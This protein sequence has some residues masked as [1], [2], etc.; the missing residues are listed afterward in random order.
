MG[1]WKMRDAATTFF[2]AAVACALGG[3]IW[4]IQM[5]MSEN[6]LLA[7]AHAHLALVG[8]VTLALFGIYYRLTPLANGTALS[9]IHALTAIPGVAVMVPGIAI[10]VQGGTSALAAAGAI[11]SL[12]SMVIFFVTVLRRGFGVGDQVRADRRPAGGIDEV[13]LWTG[14]VN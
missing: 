2:L 13:H 9:R 7:P 5:A 3:M 12:T 6:H 11:L 10:V 1:K 14:G 8:W 4:G